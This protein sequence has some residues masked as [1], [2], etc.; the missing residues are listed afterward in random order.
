MDKLAS[1]HGETLTEV[2]EVLHAQPYLRRVKRGQRPGE[3][4]YAALG[5]TNAGRYLVVFFMYK[6]TQEAQVV[7]VRDMD[8]SERRSY[9]HR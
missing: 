6:R 2:E 7:S 3:D 5:K 9:E 1:K 4:V 8:K